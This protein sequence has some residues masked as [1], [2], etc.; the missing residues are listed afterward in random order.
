M[1]AGKLS[2]H[3]LPLNKVEK[4][5]LHNCLRNLN[6]LEGCRSEFSPRLDNTGSCGLVRL[7][8]PWGEIFFRTLLHLRITPKTASLLL[9]KT[10][11]GDAPENLLLLTDFLPESLA[12]RFRARNFSFMDSC[13]NA[14]LHHPQLHVEISGRKRKSSLTSGGRPFHQAGLKLIFVLLTNPEAL[15]WTCRRLAAEAGIALGA[16][17]LTLN[18]MEEMGYLRR[19]GKKNRTLLNPSAL[20]QRW[21]LGFIETLRG[22]ILQH[23]CRFSSDLEIKDIPRLLHEKGLGDRIL[24]GGE[25]G[26][27]LLLDHP[28]PRSAVLHMPGD[29]L[30][31]MLHLQLVPDPE[32]TID[33]MQIFSPAN[34]WS[35]WHPEGVMLADPLL[36]HA[37]MAARG[38]LTREMEEKFTRDFLFPRLGIEIE[39]TMEGP[40]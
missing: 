25:L 21:E 23:S 17:S 15:H 20:L 4:E 2:Q 18:R 5:T 37:D 9:Q 3:A 16:V 33:L 13:G 35:G 26:A 12:A 36:M 31:T 14:Y 32:G 6:A 28:E 10:E 19:T 34:R 1:A 39:G 30:K 8:A 38:I 27:H 29:P 22:K 24:T 11:A 7:E 40:I